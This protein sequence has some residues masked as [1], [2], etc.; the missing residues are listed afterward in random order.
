LIRKL[1][2]LVLPL[3]LL[4]CEQMGSYDAKSYSPGDERQ[5]IVVDVPSSDPGSPATIRLANTTPR[6]L[7]Y[8]L[9]RASLERQVGDDWAPHQ[10][11]LA[12][13]CTAEVRLLGPGQ[14]ATYSFRLPQ[15]K[16][17]RYRVRAALYDQVSGTSMDATSTP[18]LIGRD[19]SD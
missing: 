5:M 6:T 10:K 17:G 3:A 11:M 18:F 7:G 4:G 14:T 13:A 16:R 2:V 9:C 8:N 1:R 19:V 12:E 15:V